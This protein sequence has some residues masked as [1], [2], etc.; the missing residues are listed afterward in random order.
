MHFNERVWMERDR[1]TDRLLERQ[2]NGQADSVILQEIFCI[3]KVIYS[4]HRKQCR[5]K[6]KNS[7]CKKRLPSKH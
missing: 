4:G 5:K 2:K 7:A 6:D 3:I 1:Q